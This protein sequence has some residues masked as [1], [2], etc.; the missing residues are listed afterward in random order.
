MTTNRKKACEIA[1]EKGYTG[2][3]VI[4]FMEGI[5]EGLNR[6]IENNR[7]IIDQPKNDQMDLEEKADDG[8]IWEHEEMYINLD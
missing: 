1:A 3:E 2:M 8:V 4:A 7:E 5:C 6:A